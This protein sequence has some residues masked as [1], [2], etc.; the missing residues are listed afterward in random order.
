LKSISALQLTFHNVCNNDQVRM[1]LSPD[2]F[3]FQLHALHYIN[4]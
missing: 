4:R 2:I 1:N 3:N